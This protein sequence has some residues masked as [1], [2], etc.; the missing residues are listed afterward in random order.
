M[1]IVRNDYDTHRRAARDLLGGLGADH[2]LGAFHHRLGHGIHGRDDGLYFLA[3]QRIDLLDL[4]LRL[5]EKLRIGHGLE[6][7][8]RLRRRRPRHRPCAERQE[9][10]EN[11]AW[12]FMSHAAPRCTSPH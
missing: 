1:T 11:C 4:L 2:R 9:Y 10:R 7:L 12:R 8:G 3:G 6:C 5:G